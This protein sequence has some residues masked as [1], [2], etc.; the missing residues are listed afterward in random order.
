MAPGVKH[1][2]RGEG[3]ELWKQGHSL[4]A[5]ADMLGV[6]DRSVRDWRD[7]D[8]WPERDDSAVL[9]QRYSDSRK[10]R[11]D[12]EFEAVKDELARVWKESFQ[13]KTVGRTNGVIV[14]GSA[15]RVAEHFGWSPAK[16]NK[17][18]KQAG[19]LRPRPSNKTLGEKAQ[20]LFQDGWS[21]PRIAKE[22][23]VNPDSVRNWLKERGES[24]SAEHYTTRMSH[25]ER[26]AWRR[27]ISAAKAT[28]IAGSGRYDYHGTRLDSS[29]EVRFATQCDRLGL[30]WRTWD[31]AA[32]GV[33]EV[34]ID[35]EVVCYAP[36]FLVADLP[37]EVKGIFDR[38]AQTKVRHFR[39]QRGRLAMVMKD[40]LLEMEG[41]RDAADAS[42]VLNSACYLTPPTDPAYWD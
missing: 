7:R 30:Q 18:L 28:S 12:A 19:L 21:I 20:L 29:Y 4:N 16:A 1:P 24:A 35:G 13:A 15:A 22:L 38:L 40:E 2:R 34:N 37:V 33:I 10:K 6:S 23:E 39:D 5:I 27:S 11:A 32:D 17:L 36:D 14:Q 31:R 41:A 26:Q 8:Q 42:A 9:P 3:L 25:E